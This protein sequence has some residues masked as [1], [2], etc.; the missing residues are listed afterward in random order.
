MVFGVRQLMMES[1][2]ELHLRSRLIVRGILLFGQELFRE[3]REL[4]SMKPR[5]MR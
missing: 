5:G 1:M 4:K 3:I 2:L